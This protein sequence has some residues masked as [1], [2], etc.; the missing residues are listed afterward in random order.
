MK[1]ANCLFC[2]TQFTYNPLNYRGKYCNNKCQAL[3][4]RQKIIDGWLAGEILATTSNQLRQSV[5]DWIKTRDNYSCVICG[6]SQVNP[7]SGKI[8]V[9]IDHIDGDHTNNSPDNLRTLCP[10]CHSLT[11]TWKNTGNTK[12]KLRGRSYR[13]KTD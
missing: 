1:T 13:R 5:K 3:H 11:P 9:E 4:K 10:N 12:G 2:N 8:P 6:W 7:I